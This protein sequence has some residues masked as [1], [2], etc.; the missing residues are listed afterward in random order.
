MNDYFE[1]KSHTT[2]SLNSD[3]EAKSAYLSD[4]TEAIRYITGKVY[5][6][7]AVLKQMC[8]NCCHEISEQLLCM[9]E[10]LKIWWKN[11][12]KDSLER[13]ENN[14]LLEQEKEKMDLQ[15]QKELEIFHLEHK[16]KMVE[17]YLKHQKGNQE[18]LEIEILE[19]KQLKEVR[20][21]EYNYRINLLQNQH[22]RDYLAFQ[23]RQ[24]ERLLDE[25]LN[26]DIS[27]TLNGCVLVEM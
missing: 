15:Y 8:A 4:L 1:I 26:F 23:S 3:G 14:L 18:R 7:T 11:H 24:A 22:K 13:V 27:T 6:W 21:R 16:I 20:M 25:M 12:E 2:H 19:L 9:K 10:K 17:L 5:N